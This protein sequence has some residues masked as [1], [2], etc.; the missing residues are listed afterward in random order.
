MY[1]VFVNDKPVIFCDRGINQPAEDG[2]MVAEAD[3]RKSLRQ[4]FQAFISASQFHAL[5]ITGSMG[6]AELLKEFESL[7][8]YLEAAG[9][10]IHSGRNK[11]LFIYRFGRWDLPK[12]KIEKGETPPEAAIRE[13][14][15]ETGLHD[16]ELFSELP[17]TFHIY[18]HKGKRVLKRTYWYSMR[19]EGK[20][21]PVPQTEEGITGAEWF[22]PEQYDVILNNT[23]ASLTELIATDLKMG[24]LS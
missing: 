22:V 7:F 20:K 23:Y 11:R 8:W 15:E 4:A 6:A 13:A 19:Y 16:L 10:I 9:G 12:G 24:P 18:E 21:M 1:K 14:S 2:L 3:S 17:S 5:R